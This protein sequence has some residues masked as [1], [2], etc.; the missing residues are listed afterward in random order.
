MVEISF[1]RNIAVIYTLYFLYGLVFLFLGASIAVKDLKASKLKLSGNLWLLS[2][3]GFIHGIHEWI[4]LFLLIQSH[5]LFLYPLQAFWI[6]TFGLF[7]GLLSFLFLFQFGLAL[8]STFYKKKFFKW[9]RLGLIF[10]FV[11]FLVYIWQ[12]EFGVKTG[13]F[14]N[15]DFLIR[16][17]FGFTGS[18][19]AA[20]GLIIY[21]REVKSI[22]R[23]ISLYFMFSG[24]GFVLYSIFSG[25]ISSHVK[26]PI[27]S[28]PIELLRG[29]AALLITTFLMKGLNIFD[30]ETRTKLEQHIKRVAQAEKM[31]SL[32]QLA[33]GIAHE[34]NAPL[35]NASLGIQI[36][37]R[38]FENQ[39]K[40]Q[41]TTD[42]LD[43][44]ERNMDRA[45]TI[46]KE[47]LRFSHHKEI[48]LVPTDINQVIGNSLALL[49]YKL[50]D[51]MIEW[52]P[53]DLPEISSDTL[54]LEQVFVNIINN[55]IE[56]MPN[57]GDI[58]ISGQQL[59]D[60]VCIDI[61]DTGSGISEEY[62]SKA[63]D[64]F[65]STKEI[66]KGTGLGLSICHGIIEQHSGTIELMGEEGKGTTVTIKLPLHRENS[67]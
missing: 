19:I 40:D 59:I 13:F 16:R 18:L 29:M 5:H 36:L 17:I 50:N 22:S 58:V 52:E 27:L 47:L 62:L 7:V 35:T 42:K 56:A 41:K 20:C 11:M 64:P 10:F 44:I 55:S 6:R 25:L 39:L 49:Q 32:G 60:E 31:A 66:G 63:F 57:G 26:L 2:A 23:P 30:I 21:S 4:V 12:F 45:S 48:E 33:A 1:F 14:K 28:I 24:L 8:I 65:F 37:R 34:I 46:A 67:I 43:A 51:V 53:S 54:M 61:S 3:F 38:Q 9:A 15:T